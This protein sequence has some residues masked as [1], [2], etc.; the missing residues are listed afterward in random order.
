MAKNIDEINAAVMSKCEANY[1]PL[2]PLSFLERTSKLYPERVSLIYGER[3]YSWSETYE[4]CVRL[5]S[6]LQKHGLQKGEVVTV[7][8]ANT[9]ELFE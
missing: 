7:I 4:R 2:S 8:A 6:A 5:A 1:V 3:K 9:P